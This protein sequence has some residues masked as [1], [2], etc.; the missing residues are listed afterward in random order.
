MQLQKLHLG[1]LALRH[2]C[3]P[4]R[5]THLLYHMCIPWQ[6]AAWAVWLTVLPFTIATGLWFG[7]LGTPAGVV[8]YLLP[9]TLWV[10]M[11]ATLASIETRHTYPHPLTA[12]SLVR[13][14]ARLGPYLVINTGMLP[15]QVSAFVEGLFGPMHSEFERTPKVA[16]IIG[17]AAGTTTLQRSEPKRRRAYTVKVHW[18]YL[19][20]EASFIAIQL[21]WAVTFARMGLLLGSLGALYMAVCVGYLAFH[22][23]DHEGK[24]CFVVDRDA[25]RTL[26]SAK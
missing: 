17:A 14:I 2:P 16:T 13:R 20:A 3:A 10:I 11:S 1:H 21:T 5:R 23:G 8:T 26:R 15:H 25:R 9:S 7:A 4:V 22:Y 6:W 12:R 19:V 18:P 24:V